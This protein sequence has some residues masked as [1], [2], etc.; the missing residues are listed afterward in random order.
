MRCD[1]DAILAVDRKE[2][3]NEQRLEPQH[4]H[5]MA[6]AVAQALE[7]LGAGENA[8]QLRVARLVREARRPQR[9]VEARTL[10][11]VGSETLGTLGAAVMQALQLLLA[12]R[13]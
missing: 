5:V 8:Q 6:G 3:A 1:D 7:P 4:R 2:S 13:R 10:D 9:D 11:A 12:L